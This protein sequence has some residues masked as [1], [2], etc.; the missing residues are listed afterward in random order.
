MPGSYP[1][2]ARSTPS[3][4]N[5]D[6]KRH[7]LVSPEG[8]VAQNETMSGTELLVRITSSLQIPSSMEAMGHTRLL[9]PLNMA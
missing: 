3:C 2:N 6:V 8:R 7:G 4:D 5:T 9:G 1:L